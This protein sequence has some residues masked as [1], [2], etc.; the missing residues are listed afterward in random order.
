MVKPIMLENIIYHKYSRQNSRLHLIHHS[1]RVQN[2]VR[3]D[4]RHLIKNIHMRVFLSHASE[5]K[6][7]VEQI[8][9]RIASRFPTIESW[10]DKYEILGGDDLID[11]GT[12]AGNDFR[13]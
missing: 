4:V 1:Q 6:K 7:L 3:R 8:H 11:K 9:L 13:I 12:G 5:D 2:P 10:L